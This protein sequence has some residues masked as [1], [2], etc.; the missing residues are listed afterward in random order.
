MILQAQLDAKC[1]QKKAILFAGDLEE[2]FPNEQREFVISAIQTA[3]KNTESATRRMDV[4]QDI[5]EANK[6]DGILEK[7]KAEVESVFSGKKMLGD[8]ERRQLEDIGFT[9]T[10]QS[11]HYKVTYHKDDRYVYTMGGTP[12]DIRA[13]KNNCHNIIK[14]VF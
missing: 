9:F 11:G 5:A 7:R 8:K 3:I 12:S 13:M 4:L 10:H 2:F 1:D 6:S 14:K